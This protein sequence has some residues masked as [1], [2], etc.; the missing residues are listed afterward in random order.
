[1]RLWYWVKRILFI[2]CIVLICLYG[3]PAI[4][5]LLFGLLA[6]LPPLAGIMAFQRDVVILLQCVLALWAVKLLF[7]GGWPITDPTP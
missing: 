3:I 2:I 1:M 6:L 4:V 7:W 5:H